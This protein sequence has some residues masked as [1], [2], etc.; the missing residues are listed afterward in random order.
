M[1]KI[2][3]STTLLLAPMVLANFYECFTCAIEYNYDVN[4]KSFEEVCGPECVSRIEY[5]PGSLYWN[6]M[7]GKVFKNFIFTLQ[8]WAYKFDLVVNL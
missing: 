8:I 1:L 5:A 2:L 4:M 6:S 3:I 7:I